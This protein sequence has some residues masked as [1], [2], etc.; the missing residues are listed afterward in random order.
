MDIMAWRALW[1]SL[2]PMVGEWSCEC[3][4]VSPVLSLSLLFFL[5][6]SLWVVVL[7]GSFDSSSISSLVILASSLSN[8]IR[9]PDELII[10]SSTFV[11]GF[12]M[13]GCL[14]YK[15]RIGWRLV[16]LSLMFSYPLMDASHVF[17]QNGPVL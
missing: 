16:C 3:L 5:F 9:L 8:M 4:S 1:L 2:H 6:L 7:L 15:R 17:F 12:S 14:W 11:S 13:S 10:W